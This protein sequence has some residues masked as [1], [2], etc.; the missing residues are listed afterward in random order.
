MTEFELRRRLPRRS[1][2]GRWGKA[3]VRLTEDQARQRDLAVLAR[4]ATDKAAH[5]TSERISYQLWRA[6]ELK[7]WLITMALNARGLY[8]PEVDIACGAQEPDVDLWEAG[9]RY[10]T[11]EQTRLLANL[12][13]VTVRYLTAW[14][15]PFDAR[16]TTM[17]FHVPAHELDADR[18][19]LVRRF[20]DDAWKATVAE[21]AR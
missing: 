19:R 18:E 9:K 2:D 5:E 11:W 1:R 10:P 20:D 14:D 15:E 17:R 21:A 12:C 4:R 3:G 13:G 16:S 8:G 6:G 7:P